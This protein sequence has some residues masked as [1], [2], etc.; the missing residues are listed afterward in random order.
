MTDRGKFLFRVAEY[1]GGV[2][3]IMTD[4]FHTKDRL[5][6]LKGGFIGFDLKPGTTIEQAE[7]VARYLNDH[8][9]SI[10]TTLLP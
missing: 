6:I 9:E 8:I 3:W 2:P 4:P 10:T 1:S 5:P 7:Q